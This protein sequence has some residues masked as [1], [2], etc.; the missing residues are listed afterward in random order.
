[1]ENFKN[2]VFI[3][4]ISTGDNRNQSYGYSVKSWKIWGEK[5]NVKVIEWTEPIT[6]PNLMK[7]TLQRYWVHDILSHNNIKYDQ[8]LIVDADTIIHPNCP[9]FFNETDDKFCAVMNDS[10]YEWVQRSIRKYGDYIFP[11]IEKIKTWEYF[12]SGFIIVNKKHEDFFDKVLNFYHDNF[13]KFAYSQSFL[14]GHDQTPLNFFVKKYNIETKLL[15]NCYNFQ[16][17][18]KKNLLH[19]PGHSWWADELIFLDSGWVYH[20]NSIPKNN[21]HVSYWM[22]RTYKK[23]YKHE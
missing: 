6:D 17:M 5:N 3:P 16:D 23:L 19:I 12:N 9:N 13:E 2:I 14:V 20:F 8:V 1:M 10:C 11:D 18:F 4:N 15:P 22:E 21:R 7:I